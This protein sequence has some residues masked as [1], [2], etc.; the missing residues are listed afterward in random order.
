[1]SSEF[2][3]GPH[4]DPDQIRLGPA[5]AS[6]V[7][8]VLYRGTLES[9]EGP[10]DV[11][12][13]M[14]QPGH[15]DR[16]AEWTLRWREQV[17]L[18]QGSEVPGLVKV[19]KGFVGPLP[20]SRANSDPS[21]SSLYMVMD[22][23]NGI[24]LDRWARSLEDPE[25]EQLLLALL[26]V[27]VALDM[28]HSGAATAGVP[29]V[30]RDIKPANIL[31]RSGG[32]TVLVDL[33]SVRGLTDDSRR[34]G[35]VGTAGYIAP[36][37]RYDG[38]YGPAADRYSLGAVAFFLLTGSDPPVEATSN[39]LRRRLA[40]SASVRGRPEVVNHVVAMLDDDP[41]HRPA[42]M[43]NWV[44]QLRRSSLMPLSGEV[45]LPP[46]APGRHPVPNAH[47]G[48]APR[49]QSHRMRWVTMLGSLLVVSIA[50]LTARALWPTQNATRSSATPTTAPLSSLA[51]TTLGVTTTKVLDK[52]TTTA[53]TGTTS[54]V[55][56][57]GSGLDSPG[58]TIPTQTESKVQVLN[59]SAN[60]RAALR[61]LYLMNPQIRKYD[62][63]QV[64]GP[65]SG[66]V[67]YA[68]EKSTGIY[69]A[70]ASFSI[71]E[72]DTQDQPEVF[73]KSAGNGWQ[74][75]GDS[76]GFFGCNQGDLKVPRSV[77]VAWRLSPQC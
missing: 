33:G 3:V 39:D 45:G 51:T 14:L 61:A 15:L 54:P 31:I 16:L 43:A 44:A 55:K 34:S 69:W 2:W 19:R 53:R 52:P 11:A 37:V 38:H 36:E 41:R 1:M 46:R 28:L 29:V 63:S 9:E 6:G 49:S 58:T 30:H 62:P 20:H 57:L 50:L 68:L 25:P 13:K 72:F 32:D 76:G 77:L 74:D 59:A 47:D 60:E 64:D 24:S 42:P 5:I 66:S 8:G 7:E 67:Y 12:V 17:E 40:E 27:A 21:T 75:L 35:V 4:K 70:L 56:A 48:A 71:P 26:P 18:L 73:S 65:L 22:W 23:E 10:V